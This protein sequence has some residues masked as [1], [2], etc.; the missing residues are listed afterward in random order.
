M[1]RTV[2]LHSKRKFTN[3]GFTYKSSSP[4]S[5]WDVFR[6]LPLK[7]L[8]LPVPPEEDS[9]LRGIR[10]LTIFSI[11]GLSNPCVCQVPPQVDNEIR[12]VGPPPL[13]SLDISPRMERD[14]I[15]T[16]EGALPAVL[17]TVEL[18]LE[19]LAGTERVELPGT[20]SSHGFGDR[21]NTIMRHPCINGSGLFR[22]CQNQPSDNRGLV[23]LRAVEISFR[24]LQ[25]P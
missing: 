12:F 11:S 3:F 23:V 18:L 5:N 24:L 9:P 16:R 10:T 25:S 15:R 13:T 8:S 1:D 22:A 4:D 2:H 19:S 21:C 14:R 6:R 7:Q 20:L 17:Q